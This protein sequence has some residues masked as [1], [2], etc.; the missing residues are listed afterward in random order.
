MLLAHQQRP[1]GDACRDNTSCAS[2][3]PQP[4]RE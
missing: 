2:P 4:K 3:A 1:R